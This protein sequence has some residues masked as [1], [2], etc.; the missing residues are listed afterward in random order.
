MTL[1]ER[2]TKIR[3]DAGKSKVDFASVLNVSASLITMLE[4]GTR[5]LTP[6]TAA[7]I[8]EKFNVNQEWLETGDGEPYADAV[9][10]AI[11][12][13]KAEYSL[14]DLDIQIIENYLELSPI[15]RQVFKDYIKT[16]GGA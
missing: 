9:T 16:I 6:R 10:P 5:E 7:D 15:E 12:L 13:L 8:C 11:K 1:A 3:T 2:L 14:D 4:K